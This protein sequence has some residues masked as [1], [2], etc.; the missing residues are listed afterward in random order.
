MSYLKYEECHA[1]SNNSREKYENLD[2]GREISFIT[3]HFPEENCLFRQ[4]HHL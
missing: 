3:N 1:R 4:P 2:Q